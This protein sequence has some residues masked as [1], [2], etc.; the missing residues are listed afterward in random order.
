LSHA[1]FSV[2]V[3]PEP[4]QATAH[5]IIHGVIRTCHATEDLADTLGLFFLP[6]FLEAWPSL[7]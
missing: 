5:E 4:V 1:E 2:P 3:L 6:D 7:P